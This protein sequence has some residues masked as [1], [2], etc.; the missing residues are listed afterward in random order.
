MRRDKHHVWIPR[1]EQGSAAKY[2]AIVDAIASD[3]QSGRLSAG[4]RMTPQRE[5]A[6]ALSVNYATVSR[7][8]GEA[9]RRGLIYSRVGQGTFVCKP[10]GAGLRGVRGRSARVDMTMNMPPPLSDPALLAR[11][12]QG[13]VEVSRRLSELLPYQGFGGSL[14]ARAA[15]L[16]WLAL[17]QLKADVERVLVCPGVQSALVATLNTLVKPGDVA[18]CEEITYPGLKAI[19]AQLGIRLIGLPVD[20]EGV[21]AAAFDAA[22]QEFHP[23]VFYCN[24]TM[25]NPT[26]RTVSLARRME[27]VRLCR[28]HGLHIVEDDPYGPLPT[29]PVAAFAAIAPEITYYVTGLSKCVGAGLRVAYLVPPD[30]RRARQLSDNLR[31]TSVM[32]SPITVALATQWVEDGTAEATLLAIRRESMARQWMA[33]EILP[34]EFVQTHP[35]GFHLWLSLP[36]PWT[37]GE[38]ARHVKEHGVH[39]VPSDGFAVGRALPEAVRVCLGGPV[40]V[41]ELQ[42]SLGTLRD[43]LL[44]PL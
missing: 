29:T 38:F 12:Q 1:V 10:R 16:K 27:L 8:Y 43:A 6:K 2:L 35:E 4:D 18:L 14:A 19:A 5:V 21:R 22:C 33:A 17:T 44:E 7:A 24:P 30:A 3:I 32:A 20:G 34:Q 39:V 28:F 13:M 25:Q 42:G 36:Q 26:T 37:R 9:Q 11:M 15:A 41:Q 40:S 23:K 31:A